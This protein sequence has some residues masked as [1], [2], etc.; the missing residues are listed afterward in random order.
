MHIFK[1]SLNVIKKDPQLSRLLGQANAERNRQVQKAQEQKSKD[2]INNNNNVSQN[3]L[4]NN[5]K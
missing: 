1:K 3:N 4:I 5:D 2:N